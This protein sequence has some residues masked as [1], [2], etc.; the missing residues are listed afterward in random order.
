M[1]LPVVPSDEV[2]PRLRRVA[3][4]AADLTHDLRIATA[5][6]LLCHEPGSQHHRNTTTAPV[7]TRRTASRSTGSQVPP[8]D[9]AGNGAAL[10][11]EG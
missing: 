10:P 6:S 11:A 5:E 4:L 9:G 3:D 8:N 1:R 7:T 2:V